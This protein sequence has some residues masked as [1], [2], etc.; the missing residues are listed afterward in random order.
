MGTVDEKR[1]KFP[2]SD[3]KKGFGFVFSIIL[4]RLTFEKAFSNGHGIFPGIYFNAMRSN[5]VLPKVETAV[6][7]GGDHKACQVDREK[8]NSKITQYNFLSMV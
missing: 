2:R 5:P 7:W 3:A 8:A 1:G 6:P 4:N